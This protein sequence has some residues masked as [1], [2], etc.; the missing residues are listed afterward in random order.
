[1]GTE[2]TSKSTSVWV[3]QGMA[4]VSRES[5]SRNEKKTY[6]KFDINSDL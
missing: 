6:A 1:M 2:I 5:V 3:W 4:Y